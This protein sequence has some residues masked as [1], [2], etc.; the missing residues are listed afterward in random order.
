MEHDMT[1]HMGQSKGRWD[2]TKV[3]VNGILDLR[4]ARRLKV[5]FSDIEGRLTANPPASGAIELPTE[6]TVRDWV[7]RDPYLPEIL[8]R[9]GVIDL[10]DISDSLHTELDTS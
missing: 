5:S 4:R 1:A 3:Q 2:S 8:H 9:E 7:R 10:E 6:R